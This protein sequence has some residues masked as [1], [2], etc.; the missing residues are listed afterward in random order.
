MPSWPRH[1]LEGC[2]LLLSRNQLLQPAKLN[3]AHSSPRTPPVH[4]LPYHLPSSKPSYQLKPA[5][6][7]CFPWADKTYTGVAMQELRQV[8]IC[9][10]GTLT[11]FAEHRNPESHFSSAR[12]KIGSNSSN[13]TTA[14]PFPCIILLTSFYQAVG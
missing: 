2:L 9:Y 10:Q 6:Q 7:A 4:P 1:R 13:M 11:L 8:P 14:L 5:H 12:D 3:Q